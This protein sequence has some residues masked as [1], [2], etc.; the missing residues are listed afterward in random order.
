VSGIVVNFDELLRGNSSDSF[1]E[2]TTKPLLEDNSVPVKDT[3]VLPSEGILKGIELED[4]DDRVVERF[5]LFGVL[6]A[7]GL[8]SRG[9]QTSKNWW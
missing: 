7:L 4:G 3:S 5:A 1:G 8:G 2:P 6:E 9:E